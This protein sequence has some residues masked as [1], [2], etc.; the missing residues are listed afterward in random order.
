MPWH[1]LCVIFVFWLESER[2]QGMPSQQWFI[3]FR[4]RIL[5]FQRLGSVHCLLLL[6]I[7]FILSKQILGSFQSIKSFGL[8]SFHVESFYCVIVGIWLEEQIHFAGLR[9]ETGDSRVSETWFDGRHNIFALFS[10]QD[11]HGCLEFEQRIRES[12]EVK[13][14]L[15]LSLDSHLFEFLCRRLCFL[16]LE[17]V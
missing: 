6:A 2:S 16:W 15:Q 8:Q 7:I 11:F 5:N 4:T 14:S 12:S 13:V 10:S 17:A 9:F 3:E 1:G